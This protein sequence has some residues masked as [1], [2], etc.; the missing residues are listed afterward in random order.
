MS[1]KPMTADD[2]R[3][4]KN[5]EGLVLQGCGGSLTE[6]VDGINDLLTQSG[7]LQE[8][9]KFH[10]CITFENEGVT[11][12]LFP[13]SE[14]TKLDMGKLAIWR[15][16]TYESLGGTWLSDYVPNQLGGFISENEIEKNKPDCPLIGEDGNIFNLIG[17]AA[18]TLRNN[19]MKAEAKEMSSRVMSAGSYE[20]ALQIIGEYVN[21]TSSDDIDIESESYDEGMCLQ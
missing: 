21:I 12:L 8:G 19:D 3:H 10:D 15:L 6:W 9:S 7:I 2:I 1:I 5:S 18:R 13:F 20:D 14:D 16:T 11:C 4:L 17:I